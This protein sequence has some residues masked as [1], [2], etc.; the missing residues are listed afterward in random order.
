MGEK[1]ILIIEDEFPIRYLI[2]HQLKE[3]GFSV[4]MAKD[5][6]EGIREALKK[7]PDLI[8][9]DAM[10]PEMDG[11]EVCLQ[12]KSDPDTSQIP[13]I[14]LTANQT[15]DYRKRAFHVGADDF[16]T[17]PFKADDL[18]AHI[19]AILRKTDKAD[20]QQIEQKQT[21][22]IVSMFSPKGGVGTTTLAI[23]LAESIVTHEDEPVILIDLD[24]PFGA[25]AP[26]LNIEPNPNILDLLVTPQNRLSVEFI[27]KHVQ[28]HRPELYVLPAPMKLIMA[29]SKS[30]V[31]NL[32]PLLDILT[33]EGN[34]IILDLGSHL[35]PITRAALQ[36]SDV[37]F[38]I[39]SG[40]PI[41]NHLV[42]NFIQSAEL[43]GLEQRRLMPVINDLHNAGKEIELARVPVA[44]IPSQETSGDTSIWLKEQGL[45][46]LVSVMG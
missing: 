26:Y 44:H 37:I 25:I 22:Q 12:I 40:E 19:S 45:R 20:A 27:A 34:K 1:S 11:F 39:T 23:Q 21:R 6:P 31:S 29:D 18:V 43:L 3:F 4:M 5:G 7:R 42:N 2:E 8:V 15:P 10:M 16:L 13:V 46:K 28:M 41:A 30:L 33:E 32:R 14:F 36:Y 38:T 24:F 9:L 17:K 35:T